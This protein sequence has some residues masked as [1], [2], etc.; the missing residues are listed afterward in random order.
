MTFRPRHNLFYRAVTAVLVV[1]LGAGASW[2]PARAGCGPCAGE[3]GVAGHHGRPD[4]GELVPD[5][6]ARD[7]HACCGQPDD[8][9]PAPSGSPTDDNG[10]AGPDAGGCPGHCAA[11]C[12]PVGRT[13]AL[14]VSFD[15]GLCLSPTA[16]EPPAAPASPHAGGVHSS[17]FH[18][19]RA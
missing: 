15:A 17:V 11:C 9:I 13:T 4:E 18:P 10:P 14:G 3:T 1:V 8:E 7:A 6:G 12:L 5:G 19:P 16:L 2:A